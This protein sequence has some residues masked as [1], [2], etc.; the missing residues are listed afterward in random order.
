MSLEAIKRV[1][2]TEQNSLQRKAEAAQQAKRTV[3]EAE[4]AGQERLEKARQEAEAKAKALMTE[5]E[6]KA[7]EHAKSVMKETELACKALSREAGA[8]LDKAAALIVRR[9][10]ND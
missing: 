8:R 3:A 7:A 1:T 10:V 5:A 6:Q 9:V 4:R 2:E